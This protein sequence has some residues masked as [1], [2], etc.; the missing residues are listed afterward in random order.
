MT[1]LMRDQA[2]ERKGME[3]GIFRYDIRF[4]RFKYIGRYHIAKSTG[5]V[6]F[7]RGRSKR[8]YA[9]IISGYVVNTGRAYKVFCLVCF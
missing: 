7:I 2:N 9:G 6:F 4:K 8:V 1:L 3:K 5:K